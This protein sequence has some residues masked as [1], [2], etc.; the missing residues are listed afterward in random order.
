MNR[1]NKTRVKA[2]VN[3]ATPTNSI[4]SVD[5]EVKQ[6]QGLHPKNKHQGRY[7][8]KKLIAVLPELKNY[9]IKTPGNED[10]VNFSNPLA[11][12][13]LNKALLF[14]H[15]HIQYWDIPKGYLCPPIPGRADYIH[16]VADLLTQECKGIKHQMVNALDIGVG[17]NCIYPIVAVRDYKWRC[18]ASDIDPISIDNATIIVKRNQALES[19]ID[20]RLQS[21]AKHIFKNIIQPGEFF[22]IT[23]CNPPFH[24]SLNEAQIG[25]ERKIKNLKQNQQKKGNKSAID[26]NKTNS[27][28]NFGGQKAELWCPGGEAEFIKNLVIESKEFSE[29]VLWFS[30]LVSKK[31]NV[32][33]ICKNLEK[34]AVN[35]IQILEMSQG[36]K[37]SRVVAWSFKSESQRK[38]WLRLKT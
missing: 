7:D 34:V 30:T 19:K 2:I 35:K 15:Y 17:A 10:S 12:I 9:V 5:V 18:V 26:G 8:F 3:R 28:L 13:A 33:W 32:R 29:Q 6:S 22:D 23:T 20:C 36:Q 31:E 11:V 1:R 25:T 38:A 37:K 16:R 21:N 4:L 14:Y 27:T 24:K